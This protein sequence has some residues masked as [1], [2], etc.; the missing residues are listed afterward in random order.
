MIKYIKQMK[1]ESYMLGLDLVRWWVSK[2]D[3][4]LN[5]LMI[6][7]WRYSAE[8]WWWN[9]VNKLSAIWPLPRWKYLYIMTKG[10]RPW[11]DLV[12]TASNYWHHLQL[13][14]GHFCERIIVCSH[15]SVYMVDTL[16]Q[17][18]CTRNCKFDSSNYIYVHQWNLLL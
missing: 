1:L 16:F 17:T 3:R 14:Q 2:I 18:K 9:R 15:A 7:S 5:Q 12:L 4:H 8:L 10:N 13:H 11:Y 6:K